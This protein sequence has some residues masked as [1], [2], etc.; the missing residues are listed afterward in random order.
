MLHPLFIAL[1]LMLALPGF[2]QQRE[3]RPD[4]ATE[5]CDRYTKAW[6]NALHRTKGVGLGDDF[7]KAHSTF[8]ADGCTGLRAVCPRSAA[9]LEMANV[10][11]MLALN[12]GM[13][14]SFLPFAC[15]PPIPA[16]PHP[17][18]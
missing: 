14:G 1:L 17:A 15:R 4:W 10:M 11:T 6:K 12:A 16:P 2:A 8:L 18:S 5:K 7:L 9:E 3:T 13:S